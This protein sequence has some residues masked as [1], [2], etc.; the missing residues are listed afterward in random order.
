[1]FEH[2]MGRNGLINMVLDLTQMFQEA[3]IRSISPRRSIAEAG[4]YHHADVLPSS[5]GRPEIPSCYPFVIL[6]HYQLL[7]CVI[8]IVIIHHHHHHHHD[9]HDH[10]RRRR[11][12][13]RHHRHRHGLLSRTITIQQGQPQ[14][15]CPERLAGNDAVDKPMLC[16]LA[17]VRV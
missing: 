1:M 6:R 13:R 7:F 9:H 14:T 5:K 16:D 8:I 12:R 17:H 2:G 10:R 11:H 4:P 3:R 15:P